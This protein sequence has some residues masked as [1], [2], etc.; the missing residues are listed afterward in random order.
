MPLNVVPL[1]AVQVPPWLIRNHQLGGP[2][3]RLRSTDRL[4]VTVV[5]SVAVGIVNEDDAI[6]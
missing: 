1:A 5:D 2:F 6:R 4:S 3:D